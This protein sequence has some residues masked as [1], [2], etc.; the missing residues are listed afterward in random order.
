MGAFYGSIHVRTENSDAVRKAL[1]QVAKEAGCNFLIGPALNGW[2]SVFPSDSGQNDQISANIAKLVPDD[3]FHLIVHDDDI[4]TY[5]FYRDGRLIDQYNS[6]PDYFEEV[7]DEE[8]QR[9]QGRPELFQDLFPEPKTLGQLKTLLAADKGKFTF[10]SERMARFAELLDLPNALSSYEYLQAGERD[11]IEGWEQFIHIEG[12]GEKRPD[13]VEVGGGAKQLD[14]AESINLLG[15]VKRTRGD[16]DGALADFNK[17]IELKP[18]LAAAW[19]NRGLVKQ[20][21]GDRAGALA[22]FSRAIELK[23]D[24]AAA[25]NNRGEVK[26]AKGD[27]DDALADYNRAIELKP[28]LAAAYNN[29]A[30]V[31][32]AKADL[33]GALADFSRAIEL[34]PDLAQVYNNRGELKRAQVDL[35]GALADYDKAIELKPDLAAAY[36]NRGLLKQAKGDLDGALTDLNRAIELKPELAAGHNN[37]GIAKQVKGDLDGALADFDR[38]IELKAGVTQFHKNRGEV[39][40]VKGNLDGALADFNRAIELNSDWADTYNCRGE[41]KR[42]K[43]DFDGALADFNKAL[44]LKPELAPAYNNRGLV[45]QAKGDLDGAL[46]DCNRTIELNPG[47]AQAY[48]NRGLV[49]RARGDLDGALADYDKA[50]ELKPDLAVARNNRDEAKRAQGNPADASASNAGASRGKIPTTENTLVLRTDFSDEP[51]WKSLCAAIQ[52]PDEEFGF[53]ANVDFVSDP[54][55]DGLTADQLPSL[56]S[57]DSPLSFVFIIDRLALS[58]PDHPILVI[59]LQDKPG[60]TFRVISSALWEVENNLSIANMG[61]EEFA[62]AVDQDG[63]FRGFQK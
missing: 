6:C 42:A 48:N 1:E 56:L 5:D 44:E 60:R 63:I 39:K 28:D 59:G 36:N 46:A 33:E 57:E 51:A 41:A 14:P 49:K 19:N 53:T 25:Y 10:E 61:F 22:D 3:I 12:S 18:D 55:Y 35:N 26:R 31:K 9:C 62:S 16:P 17:A 15:H 4:F 32:R 30:E 24:L 58:H 34:K 37:R 2:I 8:K 7:S 27:L 29:R 40:R 50:L 11:E 21:K 20:T 38:A 54:K 43:K 45:K 52:E 23:P 47:A 13:L